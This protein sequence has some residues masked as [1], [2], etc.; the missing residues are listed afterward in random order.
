MR[1]NSIRN[2]VYLIIIYQLLIQGILGLFIDG[3]SVLRIAVDLMIYFF[4]FFIILTK[5]V[6]VRYFLFPYFILI[7][8]VI[9]SLLVNQVEFESILKQV[10]FTFIGLAMYIVLAHSGF[11]KNDY[12]KLFNLLF[13]IG[14]IQLPIVVLQLLMFDTGLFKNTPAD[15]VD[16]GTGTVGF[17]DSGVT[18]MY[19]VMLLIIKFQKAFDSGLTKLDIFQII[20]LAAPLGLINSDAQFVFLPV[21]V[22]FSLYLN[23]K[24]N[25]KVLSYLLSI[26]VL[27]L[28]ANQLLLLNW[29]GDRDIKKYISSKI[30]HLVNTEPNYDPDVKRMLRYD[31]MRYVVEK[32]TH[33]EWLL[34]KGTGYW[35]TRDSEGGDSLITNV[36]YHA[37]TLL[38]A[39][40]ELGMLGLLSYVLFPIVLYFYADKSFWGKVLKI[41]SVYLFLLLFYQHPLN[42]L[43]IVIILMLVVSMYQAEKNRVFYSVSKINEN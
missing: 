23:F 16:A 2:I 9:L 1:I 14:Y 13:K 8:G 37:N 12:K 5:N 11:T 25:R 18:G 41:E 20:L 19:L 43:S 39:Y 22:V 38:L 34:G 26:V 32:S 6:K 4:A 40:G 33:D 15:Y 42:K 10:R 7:M 17:M 35:L 24:L 3:I 29:S 27:T 36:W 30:Y 28:V 21:I 31:S